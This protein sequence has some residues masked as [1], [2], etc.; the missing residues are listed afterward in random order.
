MSACC[1]YA[2]CASCEAC[3]LSPVQAEQHL[4][5]LQFRFCFAFFLPVFAFFLP[6]FA[7][8]NCFDAEALR[9][10]LPCKKQQAAVLPTQSETSCEV[11]QHQM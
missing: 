10:W 7:I 9:S 4:S 6:F 2:C 8:Q 1:M 5:I 11:L 3:L